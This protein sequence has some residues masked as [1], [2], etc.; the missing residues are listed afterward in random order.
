MFLQHSMLLDP[1]LAHV[2][3][4]KKNIELLMF[5]R[6]NIQKLLEECSRGI[7]EFNI[8][9]DASDLLQF[10]QLVTIDQFLKKD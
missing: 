8:Q 1:Q 3:S 10:L 5:F 2:H 9:N 4:T 6:V 7:N